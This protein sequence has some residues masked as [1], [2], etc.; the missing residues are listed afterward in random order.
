MK[1]Q[2][3]LPKKV[4]EALEAAEMALVDLGACADS[5]CR[6]PNCA[7]ALVKVRQVLYAPSFSR[8]RKHEQRD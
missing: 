4:S 3:R 7:H 8:E 1:E 2:R 6:E 5:E